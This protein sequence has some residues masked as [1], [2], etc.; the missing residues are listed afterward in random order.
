[1]STDDRETIV[2]KLKQVRKLIVAGW[3]KGAHAKTKYSKLTNLNAKN[4]AK[5][6]LSGA[7]KKVAKVEHYTPLRSISFARPIIDV[8][9]HYTV[10]TVPQFND[11]HSTTKKDILNVIDKA[12]ARV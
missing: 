11:L 7:C 2:N 3:C 8:V 6:C 4:A 10:Y 12:I 9:N 1:M 5:F